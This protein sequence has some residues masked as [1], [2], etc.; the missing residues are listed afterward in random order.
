[1]K[2]LK[3]KI[4]MIKIYTKKYFMI[5]NIVKNQ[6]KKLKKKYQKPFIKISKQLV[7]I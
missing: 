1:M 6:I 7:M 4:Y 5:L 2:K 3:K